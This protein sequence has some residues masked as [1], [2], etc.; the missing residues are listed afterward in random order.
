MRIL[1]YILVVLFVTTSAMGQQINPV[2]DYI[3]RNQMSVGRNAPTDTAAYM[4]IGPRYGAVK[5]FMPP[6]VVDTNAVT[7]TKRNGLLI[8]SVQLNNFAYWDST[9]SRFRKITAD[10]VVDSLVFSTRAWR[11]KGDDSLGAVIAVKTDT[12][13][14]STKAYRQKAVDSLVTLIS[15]LGGGTVLSVSAGTGMN[16]TTITTSGS[17]SADTSVLST[18]AWRKKGDDSLGAVIAGKVNISDTS[19]MLGAYLRKADTTSMLSPYLRKGDTTAML[20]P[21]VR[22]A[23]YGLLKGTQTLSVDSAL[24]ATRARVQKG[25]DSVASLVAAPD[26]LLFSTRAWR[27]KGDD[28]LG[29]I[30]GTKATATGT[31]NY[32][33]KFT[34]TSSLGNSIVYAT[35]SEVGISTPSPTHPL[36]VNGRTRVRTIDST[37]TG[38]NMLYADVDGVIKKAAIPAGG[39][40]SVTSV[41]AGT[42]MSFTTITS[43]GSVNA[44]TVA[45]S[46][47][48]WRQKGIDSV[49]ANV[50]LKVNISDTATMLSP[51]VRIAGF[52]LTKGTQ[53]LSVDSAT[54]ATRARVQKGIDSVASVRIG[55]SGTIN[56]IPKFTASGT[57]GDGSIADSSSSV[58][59]YIASGGNVGIGAA[60]IPQAQL[61]VQNSA[62]T[63]TQIWGFTGFSGSYSYMRLSRSLVDGAFQ[64][65]TAQLGFSDIT[66]ATSHTSAEQFAERM[67]IRADGNIGIGTTSPSYLLDVNGTMRSTGN[68]FLA[69]S[70]TN[71]TL[72]G[73]T[74]STAGGYRLQVAGSIYNTTGAVFAATSGNV[75]IGT[76][77]VEAGKLQINNASNTQIALVN[78]GVK[79]A[80]YGLSST[81]MVMALEGSGNILFKTGS[82]YPTGVSTGTTR[83]RIESSGNV[84]IGLT[85]T[86]RLDV[87]GFIKSS[88]GAFISVNS[89]NPTYIGS[90]NRIDFQQIGSDLILS[91]TGAN[92]RFGN[93]TN[94][95]EF[96][97]IDTDGDLGIGTTSPSERLHVNGRARI[98]TIDSSAGPINM[99]WAD[100]DGVVR[101]TAPA[102]QGSGTTNRVSKFTAS[103][104]IGNGGIVDETTSEVMRITTANNVGI[105]TVTPAEKLDVNGRIRVQQVDSSGTAPHALYVNSVGTITRGAFPAAGITGS[106]TVNRSAKFTAS[107]AIGNGGIFDEVSSE[108]MRITTA[109][110]V[111]IATTTPA[112][113]LDVNG[114]IRVQQVDSSGTAPHVLY[115]NSV[116]TITKG[117]FQS[118]GGTVTS[119][120][121][122]FGIDGGTITST[123]TL[124]ADTV[125]MATRARVQKGIDSVAGLARVTGSG[126]ANYFPYWTGTTAL[127]NSEMYQLNSEVL[128]GY[129]ADQ[130]THKLQVNGNTFTNGSIKTAAPS[131]GTAAEWKLG[132]RVASS[133]TLDGT[134]YIEVD[135]GGTLYYLATVSFL[136]PKPKPK[137]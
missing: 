17:V 44:D 31:T 79:T 108:V 13:L 57:I 12:A 54:M 66:F 71:E 106:G 4:S 88:S 136:E 1:G 77:T 120:A 73:T 26:S 40:G 33:S 21:Y 64:F 117:A 98:A 36:D 80:W 74:T 65:G 67:R 30:I 85:P 132:T 96:A 22:T 58:R 60:T 29:A 134:Q 126:T 24:M 135:I 46:T 37:A 48:A 81:D 109:N 125:E 137:P 119:V 59:M 111:G 93:Y 6:M 86:E 68:T 34:G 94:N 53:T 20:S 76:A 114:R 122:G 14:L 91:T 83:M 35:T 50:A 18:R 47:R 124:T 51:Y 62:G 110:N 131:G 104:T 2:P 103:G 28:S 49:N 3:F 118:G 112:E 41:A 99:L 63:H 75:G 7:G 107:G 127:G 72:I 87:N 11:Q 5:G 56:R 55:G 123:G 128:I 38:M 92:V 95:T 15:T 10:A 69:T 23:G 97:R 133:V 116:G 129:T 43:T 101:K 100:V 45:L 89:G 52:G 105:A 102:V 61:H 8:F 121:T 113:K 82:T 16:F 19:T 27:Q 130:G 84:G 9:T 39:S 90:S 78:T 70:G 42:G 25:I 32:L 115:V